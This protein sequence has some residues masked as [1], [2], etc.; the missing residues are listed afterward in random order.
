MSRAP[1]WGLRHEENA[2]AEDEGPDE[3]DADDGA[4]AARAG[5]VAR[6]D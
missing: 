4:P 5:H 3:G 1:P 2:D 6:A